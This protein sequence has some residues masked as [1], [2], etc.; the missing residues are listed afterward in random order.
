MTS[1]AQ[2]AQLFQASDPEFEAWTEGQEA[3][4]DLWTGL[5]NDRLLLFYPTGKG[6]TKTSLA[7][8]A[9][10]GHEQLVVVAPPRTHSAWKRDAALLGLTITLMSHAKFRQLAT[11]FK[12]GTAFIV[13]EFHLLGG[14]SGAGFKKM[15][16]NAAGAEAIILASATPEYNDAE[17]AYCVAHVLAP[18]DHQGGFVKWVYEHCETKVNPFS[19]TPYVLGFLSYS[20]AAEFLVDQGYTAYI[21][22]DAEWV[23][24][25]FDLPGHYDEWFEKF[26]Y[27]RYR[28]RM[29]ASD[30]E[31]RHRRAYLSLVDPETERL[32]DDVTVALVEQ[33]TKR[34]QPW[35]LF[36]FHSTIAE[37]VHRSFFGPLGWETRILTGDDSSAA[38]GST[39]NWFLSSDN[40]QRVLVGSGSLATGTDGLDRVC[41][42]LL[43]LDPQEGDP[44]FERQ[45]IGRVL[46]RGTRERATSVVRA[47]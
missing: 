30:M 28:H 14:H 19:S 12:R 25:S 20:S 32:W 47:Q 26:G 45:L 46:P 22:D 31:K 15:D 38:A 17:R 10:K 33:F 27:D 37:A 39:L 9:D 1:W 11:K 23:D 21:E 24:T 3:A 7:L 16:R 8:M 2:A 29:I 35:L 40:P 4:H 44:S 43:I 5:D 34:P 6:K 36:C 41:D 13:D 42:Q 18:L